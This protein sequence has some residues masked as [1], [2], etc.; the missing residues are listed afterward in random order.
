[1]VFT[2]GCFDILH[3]GHIGYLEKTRSF[4]DFLVVGLNSDTSVRSLKGPGRPLND[5]SSRARVL[6]GLA[7]VDAVTIF[8]EETPEDL[9]R[10]VRP[11][12]LIKGGD[13]RVADIVGADF[14]KGYGG[15]VKTVPFVKGYSTT[16][17]IKKIF[18]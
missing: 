7:A 12:L 11:D 8:N 16:A 14:V 13:W 5:Q 10:A 3:A 15:R 1:M 18:R 9:I 17:T 6:A 4:G 2:N